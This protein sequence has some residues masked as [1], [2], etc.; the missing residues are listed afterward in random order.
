LVEVRKADAL[1][2]AVAGGT[3][4]VLLTEDEKVVR[5]FVRSIL[6]KNGYTV[7]EAHHGSEALRVALQHPGP[8]DLLLTDMVMPLMGG[9]LLAEKMIGLRPGIKVL[10]MSGYSE[11]IISLQGMGEGSPNYIRKP[12]TPLGLLRKVDR[13]LVS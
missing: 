13:L 3:E 2:T 11:N 12:F 8:I 5:K 6:E 10:Y 4:T 7:L 1:S 9:K